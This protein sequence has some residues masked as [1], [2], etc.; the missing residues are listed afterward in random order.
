MMYSVATCFLL[1]LFLLFCIQLWGL[2]AIEGAE[3]YITEIDLLKH[4][5]G[6]GMFRLFGWKNW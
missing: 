3:K 2:E 5:S 6:F 4:V 1:D